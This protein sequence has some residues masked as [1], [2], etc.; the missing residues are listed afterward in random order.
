VLPAGLTLDEE[1]E[2]CRALKGMMLRQETYADDTPPRAISEQLQR[3]ATPYTVIEQNFAIRTLQT[4]GPNRHS[5]FLT[6]PLETLTYHYERNPA[7]PRTQHAITLDVDDYGNVLKNVAIGYGRRLPDPQLP[8]DTDRAKQTTPLIIYTERAFTNPIDGTRPDGTSTYPGDYRTPMPADTGTYEIT[9]FTPNTTNGRFSRGDFV[10]DHLGAISLV[11]S[12]SVEY[13]QT[14]PPGKQRRLIEHIR[15]LYRPDDLGTAAGNAL[16][17]LPLGSVESAAIA[18]QAYKLAFTP[19]LLVRVYVRD[20]EPLVSDPNVVLSGA[21]PDRGGY[22]SSTDLKSAGVFPSSDPDG[23][24]WIPSG[25][26]FLSPQPDDRAPADELAYAR[27]HFRLTQR[28]RTPFHTPSVPTETT[29]THDTYDLLIRDIAD[30][31]ENRVT[32]G[33]RRPNGSIDTTKA[34]LDYRVLQASL[35]SDPN[36]NRTQVAFD[37]LGMVVGTAVMGKPAPAPVEGDSLAGFE[38][39]LSRSQLDTVFDARDPYLAAP[40]LL[41]DA[42]TRIIYDLDRFRRTRQANPD[43]RD[44]DQ[45]LPVGLATLARETHA[46]DL[47]P[48]QGLRIQITFNYSDGFGRVI[49]NKMGAEPGPLSD[50]GPVVSPR[51]IAS[52]WTIFNNKANPVRRYEPYFTATQGFEFGVTVG[53]SPILFYDP[54]ERV[55]AVLYPNHT[56]K[57]VV[58]DP[59]RRTSY[60]ANDTCAP[61]G[62]QTG[63]P[64][65]DPD[66]GGF[67]D[68]YFAGL[69]A[70]PA[71][72]T[73]Y[74]ER[75]GGALG[76]D[77]QAA[78]SRAAGHADT[79]VTAHFDALGRAFLTLAQNRVVCLGHPLDGTGEILYSRVDLDIEGNQRLARDADQQAGDPLGRIVASYDYDMRGTRIHQLS[80][81]AGARWMLNDIVG[82]PIRTM[83]TRGHNAA[84]GYDQLRRPSTLTVRGTTS[85]SDRRTFNG[86]IQVDRIEYGETQANAEEFNLSRPLIPALRLRRHRR[87]RAPG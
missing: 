51:W 24:W 23:Y 38:T 55:V 25:R 87:Q 80:M 59:W 68:G 5:V 85:D 53:V 18:G 48:P 39:D 75:I 34:G 41:A 35:V 60:D 4:T 70:V 33:E 10:T 45:W 54:A 16:K 19:G 50:G 46:S 40:A 26:T 86:D 77:A 14:P 22:Q 65:T 7:D 42:T 27:A 15:T 8:T 78:A 30:P 69:P 83:D 52:G 1:R 12:G 58:F 17:L 43:P 84:Y 82:N 37:A 61:H 20:G 66:I 6:H 72:Q 76:P 63:D 47:L 73:W 81:E 57:K 11:D 64:R 31:L 9:G 44:A 74:A 28:V 13:Q 32:A 67:V 79:P 49:Q 56:Y 36:R 2:A 21:G 71:W 62:A 29:V 3:A